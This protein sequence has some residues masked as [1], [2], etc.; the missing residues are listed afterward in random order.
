MK[1]VMFFRPMLYMGGTEIAI[2]NLLKVL[3]NSSKY[4]F[5]IG[6]SDETSDE[7]LLKKFSKYSTVINVDK[8]SIDVDIFINCSPYK[9]SIDKARKVT[10]KKSFLW[11]HHFGKSEESIFNNIKYLKSLDKVIAV[12]KTQKKI[13]L[14][15]RYNPYIYDKIKV[16]H[17]ILNT[18]EIKE[19]S[20][21]PIDLEFSK[22]LNIVTVSRLSPDKGFYRKL[23]LAKLIKEKG[24]DFK[25]YIIGSSYYSKIER[26]IKEMFKGFED[27]FIF[28]GIKHNPFRIMKHCDYLA[29]LS[30]DETWGMTITE[31]KI[32]GIPCIITDF[33]VAYE[34]IED[35]HNGIILPRYNTDVYKTRIDDILNNKQRFKDNLKDFKYDTKEIIEAWDQILN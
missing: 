18:E 15:Q 5:Y 33:P 30:D 11:F 16:I 2:L 27:C 26:E 22:T 12:S 28:L 19:K 23:E 3:H 32:L 25:W 1:K 17:N 24:I 7:R 35:M 8:N 10:C 29:L 4:E 31:A 9:S 34:Q 13:M 21:E 20:L 14:E 6:Y